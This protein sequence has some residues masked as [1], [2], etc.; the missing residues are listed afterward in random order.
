MDGMLSKEDCV[1]DESDS[2]SA[3]W[4]SGEGIDQYPEDR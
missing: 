2:D 1:A 4:H 3:R